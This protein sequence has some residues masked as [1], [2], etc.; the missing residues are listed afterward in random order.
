MGLFD[1]FPYTNV[2]ELNLDWIMEQLLTL[3]T[4][5]E[6]FVSINALKYADPIQWNIT[7]QYEKNTIVIDPL[8]GT[9]YIS[10]Q[11]VPSGVAITNTDYW[12]VVFDLGSFVV[13]AAKNFTDKFEEETTLTATFPS[14]VNDWIIWGDVLYRVTAPIIAGDQYV[15]GSNIEH[16]TA[17]D[18][19]GHIQDLNTIDKSNLVAA[20]NEVLQT[21]I[22]T[23][24]DLNDLNTVDKTNL[25]AAINELDSKIF[26]TPEDFGAVGDGVTDDTA[27]V[28]AALDTNENVLCK[29]TY[30]IT[31]NIYI[32][33]IGNIDE[34]RRQSIFGGGKFLMD[35]AQFE[36][37]ATK[38]GGVNFIDIM[39]EGVDRTSTTPAFFPSDYT[40]RMDFIRCK[41]TN[42]M[43]AIKA[44]T[45][46]AN[47]SLGWVQELHLRNCI[48]IDCDYGVYING[49]C[50]ELIFNETR[51]NTITYNGIHFGDN[52]T[53]SNCSIL[54]NCME[55]C[56]TAIR[57]ANII[58]NMIIE[59]NYFEGNNAC[60]SLAFMWNATGVANALHIDNNFIY[61]SNLHPNTIVIRWSFINV[62]AQM[63]SEEIIPVYILN[64]FYNPTDYPNPLIQIK[65][66]TP[67]SHTLY[68]KT[69][70]ILGLN[71]DYFHQYD[72]H[73]LIYTYQPD[74]SI[75]AGNWR[76]VASA[77]TIFAD[78]DQNYISEYYPIMRYG[79]KS[80]IP[81][82]DMNN[83]NL[84]I[85]FTQNVTPSD[86]FTIYYFYKN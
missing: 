74:D 46:H 8:T 39:F 70:N 25:V 35:N 76:L 21:L 33:H 9:A 22:D 30:L 10:V 71:K 60:V 34:D 20:I 15:I 79:T 68:I 16:F 28:Q 84:M 3:K 12:T 62:T 40:I 29:N 19:I 24:G 78:A 7:K 44:D 13:R 6:Q 82:R 11:P 48:I 17:E 72:W 42:F 53:I 45:S 38:N 37:Y 56:D 54:R 61:G 65:D 69:E 49:N 59:G 14:N 4:T 18:V 55:I 41:F 73:Y 36:G 31:S 47:P 57:V 77:A 83:G 85:Y 26:L 63:S 67:A 80:A 43:Y 27:A 52:C 50:W 5:I 64:N 32:K 23:C 86:K 2:H 66:G 51:F 1:H 81:Y 75:N 58:N